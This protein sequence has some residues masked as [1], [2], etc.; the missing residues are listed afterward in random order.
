MNHSY[1]GTA[2]KGS[3]A[4]LAD[5]INS[6]IDTLATFAD[7]VTGV[8]RE[9]GIEGRLGGQGDVPGAAG[10]WKDL[11]DNVNEL[12]ANLSSQVR[13]IAEVATSVT[14]GDLTRSITVEARREVAELKDNVNQMISN[15]RDT[16]K[17]NT[18]Q[19]WLK[20]NLAKFTRVLQ[21]QSE[22]V[23]VAKLILDELAPLVS[24]QQGIFYIMEKEGERP[25]FKLLASYAG[26]IRK[27]RCLGAGFLFSHTLVDNRRF[28]TH[29]SHGERPCPSANP[30]NAESQRTPQSNRGIASRRSG[31]RSRT[32]SSRSKPNAAMGT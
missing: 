19:D 28:P 29:S 12:A 31:P 2:P 14:K 26:A 7:H 25:V 5:T 24:A 11:T 4:A 22:M 30:A 10:T 23:A 9:V 32:S 18:E 17:K 27:N 21:G 16:T 6:M 15:L 13:A 20:T 3:I 8:A 1:F